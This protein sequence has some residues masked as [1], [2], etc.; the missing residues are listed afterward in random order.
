M[1][2]IL[3]IIALKGMTILPGMLIHF[4]INVEGAIAAVERAMTLDQKIFTVLRKSSDDAELEQSDLCFIGVI[5]QVKQI[6]K[7]G[8]NSIRVM[9]EG[10]ERA[11]LYHLTDNNDYLEGEV[12]TIADELKGDLSANEE[13][14]MYRVL[15]ELL[16]QLAVSENG[17]AKEGM[18]ASVG[19]KQHTVEF[20][21]DEAAANIPISTDVRQIILE[22]LPINQRFEIMTDIIQDEIE[23]NRL[24]KEFQQHVKARI[25]KGQKEYLLREQLKQLREEL[26]EDNESD[27]DRFQEQLKQL[28]APAEVREKLHKEINRLKTIPSGSQESTVSRTYIE[29]LLELPWNK[30]SQDNRNLKKAARIL[31]EDHYG[32]EKVKERILEFL[33]VRTLNG[34]GDSPIIC[35][36]GPPGTGKTSIAKSLA[37]ALNKSYV[38]MSLGGMK[39]EAE[40]RGHRK[41]YVGAMPGRIAAALKEAGVNNPLMLLD[42]IDKVG[43]DYK[44]D[45]SSALLEVLDS[46]QNYKF[47]DHY[48]EVPLDLSQILF[49]AT[50]NTTQTIPQPLLDRM[51][52][53]EVN[54]YTANEKYHIAKDYLLEKQIKKHGL[55]KEQCKISRKAIEMMIHLYTKEAGV[56]SLERNIAAICRKAAREI[57]ENQVKEVRITQSSL[58]QY[59]GRAKIEPD[60]IASQDES[61]IVTGLAWTKVGGTTLQ[62]EVNIMHG[63]GKMRLTGQMGDVMKESAEIALSYIRAVSDQYGISEDFYATHD[64]HIHI[65][66]G[67]VPKDGPSAGITM[68]TAMLSAITS[69]KVRHDA[70]MTGEITLRGRVLPI[71]GLKEKLLAAK[72][73]GV[74]TVIVP[75]NNKPELEELS[76][77]IVGGMNIVYAYAMEDVLN[78]VFV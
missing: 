26:G 53:I 67:A 30:S 48:L 1:S 31:D 52:M 49:I 4:D 28:H 68:A 8:K 22:T 73:A 24:K 60:L 42:E 11:Q 13:E 19:K 40:I 62:T 54:S 64:I 27:A 6:M 47:R 21:I 39:D 70:A 43:N 41:T 3:P 20:L 72:M 69:T 58:K 77:E 16:I 33:S 9:L 34:G 18:E 35:L 51:E 57:V 14:A 5:S 32:L 44:G 61:G 15:R 75:G 59:L 45:P 17:Q 63:K 74:K 78:A 25:D 56:R 46:E 71:G 10:L 65:P 12:C 23:I 7:L 36:V 2:V 29:T 66:E 38:R 55:S 76:E 50:A 37:K